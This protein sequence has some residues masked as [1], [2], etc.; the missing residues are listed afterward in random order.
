M[1]K[2]HQIGILW[3]LNFSLTLL[4]FPVAIMKFRTF[5][6]I[7]RLPTHNFH[8]SLIQGAYK[9]V[10]TCRCCWICCSSIWLRSFSNMTGS[11]RIVADEATTQRPVRLTWYSHVKPFR[12]MLMKLPA[13]LCTLSGSISVS[14][15]SRSMRVSS[16]SWGH[17]RYTTVISNL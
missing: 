10:H 4:I 1:S 12:E 9:A 8:L 16:K 2:D 14:P 11:A 17:T 3:L 6:E 7:N 5:L 13:K 15:T